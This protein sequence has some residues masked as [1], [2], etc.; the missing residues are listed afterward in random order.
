MFID[1]HIIV[2]KRGCVPITGPG[3]GAGAA[4]RGAGSTILPPLPS[5]TAP[6]LTPP[7]PPPAPGAGSPSLPP[8][9]G[10]TNNSAVGG[11]LLYT[12]IDRK[13]KP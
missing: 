8:Q 10:A 9:F 1:V 5:P 4:A 7:P 11:L 6:T 3:R 12:Y 13:L 2:L